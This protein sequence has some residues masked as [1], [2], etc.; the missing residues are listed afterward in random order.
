M[1]FKQK[2]VAMIAAACYVCGA[3][4]AD[5]RADLKLEQTVIVSGV[6]KQDKGRMTTAKPT[7]EKMVT[8]YRTV[9][10][11]YAQGTHCTTNDGDGVKRAT[12]TGLAVRR[13][14]RL[15]EGRGSRSKKIAESMLFGRL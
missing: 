9:D 6:P 12:F 11:E 8:Y 4:G 7:T 2:S 13:A 15:Q 10:R 3:F 5:A 1:V 14:G